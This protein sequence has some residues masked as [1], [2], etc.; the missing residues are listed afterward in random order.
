[1]IRSLIRSLLAAFALG[2]GERR[3]RTAAELGSILTA[4]T[5][6]LAYLEENRLDEAEA[7]F[8]KLVRLAP[9]EPSGHA[10]LGLVY[11]RLGQYQD[12]ARAIERAVAIAPDD[13]D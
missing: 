10:N 13:P 3:D 6:G 11:L 9:D 8:A 7:E 12:A 2:C 1:M 4:H 5:L